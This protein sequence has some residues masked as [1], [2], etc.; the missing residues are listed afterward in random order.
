MVIGQDSKVGFTLRVNDSTMNDECFF[1]TYILDKARVIFKQNFHVMAE[2][3]RLLAERGRRFSRHQFGY[4]VADVLRSRSGIRMMVSCIRSERVVSASSGRLTISKESPFGTFVNNEL[5][6]KR[7]SMSSGSTVALAT[8]MAVVRILNVCTRS[9]GSRTT[10]RRQ[11]THRYV[12]AANQMNQ[13]IYI[14]LT[15]TSSIY[16]LPFDH[17]IQLAAILGKCLKIPRRLRLYE[18]L[19]VKN[20]RP[21]LVTAKVI[22]VINDQMAD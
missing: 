1:G 19:E 22:E 21:D 10:N 17:S 15:K 8:L 18:D 13:V 14:L 9:L 6:S 5:T 16:I 20:N 7:T 12:T 11:I 2:F 4:I 3:T